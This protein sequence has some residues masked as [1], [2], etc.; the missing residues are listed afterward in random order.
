MEQKHLDLINKIL[1]IPIVSDMAR[2][3]FNL[4]CVSNGKRWWEANY[5][6]TAPDVEEI[7]K[8]SSEYYEDETEGDSLEYVLNGILGRLEKLNN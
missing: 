1:S 5:K 6:F 7:Y 3:E 2:F 8:I 4:K